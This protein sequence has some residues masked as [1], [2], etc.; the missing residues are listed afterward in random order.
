M[1]K[2]IKILYNN[3]LQ[4]RMNVFVIFGG[5]SATLV[6]ILYIIGEDGER[7]AP[8]A[9][10]TARPNMRDG[11]DQARHDFAR[12]RFSTTQRSRTDCARE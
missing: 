10:Q 12:C 7:R 4:L 1:N 11:I 2:L 6:Y 5:R 8:V 9:R 3:E